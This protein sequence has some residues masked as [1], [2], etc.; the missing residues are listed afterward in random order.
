MT[1]AGAMTPQAQDGSHPAAAINTPI[2]TPQVF[3]NGR[4]VEIEYFGNAPGQ[5][6]GLV[7]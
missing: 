5:V 1:G 4:L 3:V 6:E 7:Q 2:A